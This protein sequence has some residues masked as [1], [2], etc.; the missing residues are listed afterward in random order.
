MINK[1]EEMSYKDFKEKYVK[2]NKKWDFDLFEIRCKKCGS[3]KVEFNSDMDT[4]HGYY[5]EID[6]IGS[7]IV[8]CRSCGNA[9]SLDF[10]DLNA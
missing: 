4:E 9:F 2:K 5:N 8:K 6:V 1:M 3:N 10:E 7:L